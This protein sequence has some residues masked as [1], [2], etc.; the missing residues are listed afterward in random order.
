LDKKILLS[1]LDVNGE[2]VDG[3]VVEKQAARIIFEAEVRKRIDPGFVELVTGNIFRTRVYPI[4]PQRTRTVR[5]IYQDQA[6]INNNS[7]LY[8]IP[9]QYQTQLESL[10]IILTCFGSETI[11]PNLLTNSNNIPQFIDDGNGNC[12]AECHLTNVPPSAN[13]NQILSYV[14][15]DSHKPV[16]SAIEIDS[17]LGAYF[18]LN[19]ALP[20]PTEQRLFDRLDLSSKTICIL[21]DASLS[22]SNSKENRLLEFN[23]L[24]KIFDSWLNSLNQIEILLIIFRNNMDEPISFKLERNNSNEFFKIF[25]DLPYDG[26]TNLSQLST[27]NLSQTINYYFLVSDCISTMNND[28]MQ[29][30]FLANF[31]APLWIINGNN[32]HEP[33]DSDLIRYLTEYNQYG[34]GYLNREKLELNSNDL[35]TLIQTIQIKYIQI[36]SKSIL[37]Q[38]YPSKSISI[39]LNSDRFLLVGQIPIPSPLPNSIDFEL[40][41]SMNNQIARVSVSLDILSNKSNHFGLIRRLWAQEKINELN[42][43]KEKNKSE[44]LSIGLEYSIVSH[45]TSLL[46]LENLQQHLQYHVCPAKSRTSL[47]NQ[48]QQYKTQENQKKTDNL[49]QLVQIWNEKCQWYDQVITK[50]DRYV[51]PAT[52]PTGG[53]FFGGP[54]VQG[55]PSRPPPPHGNPFGPSSQGFSFG[56]SPQGFA[57]GQPQQVFP[58]GSQPPQ[59]FSFGIPSQ[60]FGSTNTVSFPTTMVPTTTSS[61]FYSP[62]STPLAVPQQQKSSTSSSTTTTETSTIILNEANSALSYTSLISATNNPASAYSIYLKERINHRQSPSFYF[63]IASHFLSPKSFLSALDKF[64]QKEDFLP[65]IDS[66]SIEYGLR[67]LTNILELELE[68]P[69]LYRTVAYK[70]MELKQWNMALSLFRKIYSLRSDEPQSLRDLALVLIELKQYDQAL[71][72]FKQILTQTWDTRFTTIQSIVLL[73][74]NRLLNL[75]N[76]KPSD[77][78]RRLLRHLSLDIRIVVQW[79]TPDTMI[80]L[81]VQEPTG[82]ICGSYHSFRTNIGGYMTNTSFQ[83]VQPIEYLLRRSVHGKYL[84][85]LSFERNAQH[86]LTG[87]TTALVYIYK[88]FG[89]F[90]EEQQIKTV[91]LTNFQEKIDVAEI[92]FNHHIEHT[93]VTCDVCLK[94]PIIGDRYKC[95]FC[96]DVDFCHDC[97]GLTNHQHD[98]KHPLICIHDSALY[99][100][101]LTLQNRSQMIHLNTHCMLCSVSPIIG[102]RYECVTCKI[103][104][105]EKCEFLCLH[106]VSHQRI[107]TI[108]PL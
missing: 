102:I 32:L 62:G 20:K 85:S 78:D 96:P 68:A 13:D 63:D 40:E 80:R 27:I 77:I 97:Q 106:D 75:M 36:H 86:T 95:I 49:A 46:V 8:Q 21:W 88:Y 54:A 108:L 44:I 87:V 42:I 16:L 18:A 82:Q 41:F 73:D 22:R 59:V 53:L 71:E 93:N 35:I 92:E 29:E 14:L 38:I 61:A 25:E 70:L 24:K 57:P 79:D 4:E 39:P 103:N 65:T 67:I 31:R 58:S 89:A 10:D 84:I 43:F 50:T 74:L 81:S 99:T 30:N 1:G 91:R 7:F 72:Y 100:S 56:N 64:N 51:V 37:Q 12:T 69:Q 60:G 17:N 76:H 23:A 101:S 19:C 105:C 48:Y 90:G 98:P 47:Y 3:V 33:I 52:I 9:V 104:I 34:G 66:K 11:K 107:K 26:A 94:T 83:A 6:A 5:I 15:P 28:V 2:I 55:F 45:F